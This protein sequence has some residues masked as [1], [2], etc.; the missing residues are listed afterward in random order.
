MYQSDFIQTD[1]MVKDVQTRICTY[2]MPHLT[3]YKKIKGSFQYIWSSTLNYVREI[4]KKKKTFID[5]S[6]IDVVSSN[7]Y[8]PDYSINNEETIIEIRS[9]LMNKIKQQ[10][11][12]INRQF[13]VGMLKYLEDNDYDPTGF[14]SHIIEKMNL[15]KSHYKKMMIEC[16]I[17]SSIFNDNKIK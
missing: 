15:K 7:T 4:Q 6:E 8:S 10:N 14:K 16:N 17:T 13:L 2:I 9:A 11:D 5:I 12:D 3:N 1:D